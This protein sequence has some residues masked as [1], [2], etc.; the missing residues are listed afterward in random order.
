MASKWHEKKAR[1][2]AQEFE[3][4]LQNSAEDTTVDVAKPQAMGAGDE[5]IFEKKLS[6]EEKKALAKAKREAKKKKKGGGEA[7]ATPTTTA[8]PT[9]LDDV[10]AIPSNPKHADD[11]GMDHAATDALASAGTICTFSASRKGVDHSA[12][13]V[14]VQN[15]TLQHMGAVM[16]EDTAIVLNHGNRYG[17]IGR[18]G[19]GKSTLLAAIGARAFPIPN[20]IDIFHLSEE[21]EPSDTVTAL[22]AVMAVD[23]E[24]L[25]LEKH[26]DD[27]NQIMASLG[28]ENGGGESGDNADK[29]VEERQEEIM[30]ALNIV[31][32]RLDALDADTA[33]VRARQILKGESRS[34]AIPS[35]PN[36]F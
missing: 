36:I 5:Q 13:D 27:L 35:R 33:E 4:N 29:T 14:N 10:T 2:A 15:F 1:L 21:V 28:E 25:R 22:D 20:S 16:L 34:I 7:D 9:L 3:R 8:T 30:D 19:A 17:L 12:R 23:A 6:K 24:R 11:D 31:Y 26:A 18:N 32:E